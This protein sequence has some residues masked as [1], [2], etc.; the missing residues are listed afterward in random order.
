M[1]HYD[2]KN[3][4]LSKISVAA[5][6]FLNHPKNVEFMN[7]VS[8]GPSIRSRAR[9][10][11]AGVFIVAVPILLVG[12]IRTEK[13]SHHASLLSEYDNYWRQILET[14][15]SIKDLDVALWE[16]VVEREFENGQSVLLASDKVR[17]AITALVLQRPEGIIIGPKE[18]LPGLASRL[19]TSIK[20]AIANYSPTASVRLSIMSLLKEIRTIEKQVVFRAHTER[21]QTIGALSR[22]GRDQL[23]LFLV[24][25]CSLPIFIGFLPGWLLRPL[26]RLRQMASKIETGHFRDVSVS[27]NDE[28]SALAKSLKG[29]FVRKE[30][31]DNKKSSKIFELRNILRST[32]KRVEEPVFIV[33]SNLKINYTNESAASLVAIPEHQIEGAFLA[34]CMYCPVLKKTLEK[35]FSGDILEESMLATI[36]LS[37]GRSLSMHARIGVVRNRDGEV[38]RA[39]LVLEKDDS[40]VA[41]I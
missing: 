15:I 18:F 9:L 39:V 35:A 23:I 36:E 16:Y 24:L 7:L 31:I 32:L 27:G 17:Q 13:V 4:I 10:A 20:R 21:Q 1:T 38:S 11:L 41:P 5:R 26:T 37:D 12:V 19:D 25:L 8:F 40:K 22:V 3:R 28:V 6:T 33:D 29:L 14:K 2:N 30:E 34:D